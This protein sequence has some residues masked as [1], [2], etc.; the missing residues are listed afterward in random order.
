M[1][2]MLEYYNNL[3]VLP[4]LEAIE[5]T[6]K[7]WEQEAQIDMFDCISLPGLAERYLMKIKSPFTYFMLPQKTPN[8]DNS[9]FDDM[10]KFSIVGG[11]AIIFR[12]FH[13]AFNPDEPELESTYIRNKKDKPFVMAFGMDC[14]SLIYVHLKN[15]CE[16]ISIFQI[17]L[18]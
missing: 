13:Q 16:F 5:K 1:R 6:R 18:C 2:D 14:V 8:I 3:D 7:F 10:M 12:R 11:P 15:F 4:F 9:E 17:I